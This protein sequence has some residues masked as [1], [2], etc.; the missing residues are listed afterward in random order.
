MSKVF[1]KLT[2]NKEVVIRVNDNQMNRLWGGYDGGPTGP[3]EHFCT[4]TCPGPLYTCD[5]TCGF[6]PNTDIN[7]CPNHSQ[8]GSGC[9]AETCGWAYT[10]NGK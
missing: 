9:D 3:T 8:V 4:F 7:D 6:C 10:C 5:A 2:I 1:K